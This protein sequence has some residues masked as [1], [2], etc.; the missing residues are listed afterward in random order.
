LVNNDPEIPRDLA[1]LQDIAAR[2]G[3]IYGE[4]FDVTRDGSFYLGKMMEELGEVSSAYLKLS[5]RSRGSDGDPD[6]LRRDLEDEMADLFGFVLLFADWQGV[7]L[8][9][10]FARKWGKYLKDPE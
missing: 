10:V 3:Q 2:I 6:T 9:H 4:N 1:A 8:A 5:G 7:D